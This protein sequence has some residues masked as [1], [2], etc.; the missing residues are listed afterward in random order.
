MK[1]DQVHEQATGKGVT[2]AVLDEGIQPGIPS[3]QGANIKMMKSPCL[4]GPDGLRRAQFSSGERSLHGGEM[5]AFIVGNGNGPRGPGTGIKGVAPDAKVLFY[6]LDDEQKRQ[7]EPDK[8]TCFEDAMG[9]TIL[10]ALRAGA[11][12]ISMS[13]AVN[14]ELFE[15]GP[16]IKEAVA[17]NGAVLVASNQDTAPQHRAFG[18]KLLMPADVPGVVSVNALDRNAKPWKE[19]LTLWDRNPGETENWYAP[20]VAAP[21]VKLEVPG[22]SE[23]DDTGVWSTGT[24]GATALVAGSLAVVKEK[25]PH[26]TANQLIQNLIHHT[27]RDDRPGELADMQWTRHLGY[28]IASPLNML[29]H[30]PA[31]WPDE[32]PLPGDP[33]KMAQRYPSSLEGKAA[34]NPSSPTASAS[35]GPAGQGESTDSE[36]GAEREGTSSSESSSALWT[37]AGAA[38]LLLVLT[39]A[40]V[41]AL[42]RARRRN[43]DRGRGPGD[44]RKQ[45]ANHNDLNP[46]G[47]R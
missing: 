36:P 9:E 34:G 38:A 43:S 22:T 16:D 32:N 44:V 7:S 27:T 12:V 46:T 15:L 24:S 28:G 21:G 8:W 42:R 3:L 23:D 31:G 35:T 45:P 47:G 4:R 10:A 6:D 30:D 26:A 18:K 20:V 19:S 37:V 5:A 17:A 29:K 25:Y 11:D 40:A 2:V 33:T 41:V 13:W 14:N 1:L 39:A